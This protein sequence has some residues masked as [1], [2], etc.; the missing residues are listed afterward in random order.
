MMVPYEI[1][2]LI[3][4]GADTPHPGIK[5]TR[6]KV[7]KAAKANIGNIN[8]GSRSNVS[9]TNVVMMTGSNSNSNQNINSNRCI[10]IS[11]N[12]GN[13]GGSGSGS[14]RR[15]RTRSRSRSQSRSRSR[16]R[17]SSDI[18]SD[19]DSERKS[20]AENENNNYSDEQGRV[21]RDKVFKDGLKK[22]LLRLEAFIRTKCSKLRKFESDDDFCFQDRNDWRPF[23]TIKEIL[24]ADKM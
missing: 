5:T 4:A 16:S 8:A 24:I 22:D 12:N 23:C 14:H 2:T 20:D 18:L 17:S 1:L 6:K 13:R 11:H 9:S 7:F 10:N 21:E 19:S 15:S 3:I